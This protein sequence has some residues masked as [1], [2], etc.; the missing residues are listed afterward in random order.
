MQSRFP[1]LQIQSK[2][3]TRN[4]IIGDVEKA[5]VVLSAHYDTC[6]RS[7][8][9][10]FIAPMSPVISILYSLMIMLPIILVV[11]VIAQ[12]LSLAGADSL[13]CYLVSMS[14]LCALMALL[15]VGP[16]NTSNVNDNTS[17][18][19]T[20]CELMVNLS[21]SEK[22]K[23]A[24]VFFDREETGMQG[25]SF[26]RRHYRKVMKSKLLINFDCVSDGDHIMVAASKKARKQYAKALDSSFAPTDTK[27]ILQ[28]NEE[29]ILFPSDHMQFPCSVA[30]A[31]LNRKP[32]I[33][34]YINKIQTPK[35]TVLDK[36]NIKLLCDAILKLLRKL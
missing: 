36:A 13:I 8:F 2:G 1:E 22:S 29:K 10:N 28:V 33:G 21:A 14:T 7:P 24:F 31:A 27:S 3:K 9:P 25:S 34:Y 17:G 35:D 4:L 16:A 15:F 23:V 26:F 20:L 5:S 11:Q 32:F 19:I 12:L 18:V 30:V 6:A